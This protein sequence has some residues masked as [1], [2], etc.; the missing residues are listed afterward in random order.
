MDTLHKE[1][2]MSLKIGIAFV[3]TGGYKMVRALRSFRLVEP[4][5]TAHVLFNVS[6]NSWK[7]NSQMLPASWFEQQSNTQVRCVENSAFVNG[8]FNKA[9]AWL[10]ELGYDCACVF[11]D[12]IIFSPLRENRRHI[13]KWLK[14]LESDRELRQSSG[15]SLGFME[16]LVPSSDPG[17]WQRSPD[18][19]D[20]I[21]LESESLWRTLCPNGKSPLYFGSPGSDEGVKITD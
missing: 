4:D 9:I 7:K 10:K 3:S 8:S 2:S 16:A 5:L 6:S 18:H 1:D 11:H 19:W 15:I 12:D 14:M 17:C 13:S 21:D 20:L